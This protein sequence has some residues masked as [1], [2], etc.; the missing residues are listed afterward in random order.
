MPSKGQ[1]EYTPLVVLHAISEAQIAIVCWFDSNASQ[2]QSLKKLHRQW[3]IHNK[4]G[5]VRIP[6]GRPMAP[7]LELYL[8]PGSLNSGKLCF[9]GYLLYVGSLELNSALLH[10]KRLL[11]L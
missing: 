10:S 5:A 1:V 2:F 6:N 9:V 4:C 3:S 11:L 8:V 7:D